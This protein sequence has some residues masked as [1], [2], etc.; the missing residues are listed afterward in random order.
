MKIYYDRDEDILYI[1]LREV[2]LGPSVDVEDG[3]T[4]DFDDDGNVIGLEILGARDRFE[5]AANLDEL[6]TAEAATTH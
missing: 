1:R 2:P 6:A 3:V 4:L 5:I